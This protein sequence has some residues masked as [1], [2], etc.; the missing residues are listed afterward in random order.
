MEKEIKNKVR[1]FLLA[2]VCLF[3]GA[4]LVWGGI[5][6]PN[7]L[8]V[9]RAAVTLP[10][11]P[12]ELEGCRV[13]LAADTHFGSSFLEKMRR[14]R[15]IRRVSTEKADICFL[16]GDYIAAGS[17]PH[18]GAMDEKELLHFFR[19]M[20]AP[21]GCYAVLG[22]HELWYGRKRMIRLLET[23]GVQVI[24]NRLVL[25]KGKLK[26]AGLPDW[27]TVPFDKKE[28]G[29]FLEKNA[30]H[31]LLTH[32]GG[33]LKQLPSF[34][35]ITFAADTHGGQVRL[36]GLGAVGSRLN[37]R[38]ELAPGLSE[39]WGKKVFIT[40]GTGGHRIGFRLF[41]PPEIAVVTLTKGKLNKI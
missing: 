2:G 20:K 33:I 25:I 16:L 3:A 17:L 40:A 37:G 38:K 36:P 30:P 9:R 27:S 12:D 15:I 21:L 4:L 19:A 31:I 32:K 7:L 8:T 1:K 39:R 10:D 35:G 34:P 26:A 5:I 28:S 22:N 23:A 13:L 14:D 18:F 24:E 6:E 11:L 29:R 41:C